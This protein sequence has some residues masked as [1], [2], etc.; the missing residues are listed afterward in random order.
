VF[1]VIDVNFGLASLFE[2]VGGRSE[3]SL[4][5]F[6]N[7][8][9]ATSWFLVA[10][11]CIAG[12]WW[13]AVESWAFAVAML[14]K[15]T[16]AIAFLIA[17]AQTSL[18]RGWS[19]FIFWFLFGVLVLLLAGW[20]EDRGEPTPLLIVTPRDGEEAEL[21]LSLGTS[22]GTSSGTTS[23]SNDSTAEDTLTRLNRA[24][25]AIARREGGSSK[26]ARSD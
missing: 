19:S 15:W 4:L 22:S 9:W 14:I 10:S 8:V 26:D 17:F 25:E 12:A 21:G 18:Y 7:D 11:I 6:P 24:R 3:N 2:P 16:Y 1:A 13:K 20:R 5:V 23:M